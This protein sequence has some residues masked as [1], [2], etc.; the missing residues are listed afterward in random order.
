MTRKLCLHPVDGQHPYWVLDGSWP[1]PAGLWSI[2]RDPEC[3]IHIID[4]RLSKR[5]A[6]LRATDVT[7]SGERVWLWEL[8]DGFSTNGTYIN[9]RALKPGLWADLMA[10]DVLW[11]G[12]LV[13][14]VS[15]D[16]DDTS[17]TKLMTEPAKQDH[18]HDHHTE[19][20][21][22]A[23]RGAR[24]WWAEWVEAVWAWWTKQP[25]FVQWLMLVTSGGLAALLLWVWKL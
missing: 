7:Q 15:H 11:L 9:S 20:T 22:D 16:D 23:P 17:G 8:K 10:H 12:G 6:E 21:G 1:P 13:Y 14:R 5:H 25:L 2:G 19:I 18:G 4:S 3:D 24:P